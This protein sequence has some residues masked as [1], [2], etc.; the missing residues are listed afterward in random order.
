MSVRKKIV[1]WLLLGQILSLLFPL[2]MQAET[3]LPAGS[4]KKNQYTDHSNGTVTDN[5]SGLMWQSTESI[6]QTWQ[7][8]IIYAQ[9]LELAGFNDWRLPNIK[10]LASLIDS[11]RSNPAINTDFFPGCRPDAYWSSTQYAQKPGFA[12]YVDFKYGLEQ[13]GGFKRRRYFIKVVRGESPS[14]QAQVETPSLLAERPP[15][16]KQEMKKMKASIPRQR[17]ETKKGTD[18]LEPYPIGV[19]D[20]G[21]LIRLE[22]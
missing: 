16:N 4:E 9:S 15:E 12:W 7:Q 17:P 8:A 22:Y 18:I 11:T 21:E 10:E 20:D 2:N 13:N 6:P 1:S 3:T 14:L 5:S 19:G